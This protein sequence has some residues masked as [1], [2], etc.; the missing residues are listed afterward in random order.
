MQR[1]LEVKYDSQEVL[2]EPTSLDDG[3]SQPSKNIQEYLENNGVTEIGGSSVKN[4]FN[5]KFHQYFK[6]QSF[7]N[8][9]NVSN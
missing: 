7:Q 5:E 9:N 4:N 6:Q 2:E 8:Y 1:L 3:Q